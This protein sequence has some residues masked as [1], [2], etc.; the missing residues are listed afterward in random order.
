MARTKE[1]FIRGHCLAINIWGSVEEAYKH[2]RTC[3][4]TRRKS[5]LKISK[6][7]VI[8]YYLE[9]L[10]S[11]FLSGFLGLLLVYSFIVKHFVMSAVERCCATIVSKA[12]IGCGLIS[13]AAD[14]VCCVPKLS[15]RTS[16]S[17]YQLA[18]LS[19]PP[20]RF[21]ILSIYLFNW[22]CCTQLISSHIGIDHLNSPLQQV[23]FSSE[24]FSEPRDLVQE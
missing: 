11:L 10:E 4:Y 8:I 13:H 22:T 12:Q 17:L 19:F 16:S 9:T 20:S 24:G 3:V 6:F 21:F 23:R 14:R 7:S 15:L 1:I 5:I 2:R 18:S